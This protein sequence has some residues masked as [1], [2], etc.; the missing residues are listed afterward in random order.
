[1]LNIKDT[2]CKLSD[3]AICLTPTTCI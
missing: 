2:S 3:E 1:M